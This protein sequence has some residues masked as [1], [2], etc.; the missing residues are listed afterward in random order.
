MNT[1]RLIARGLAHHWRTHLG[2][3]I[4][5]ACATAVLVGA[6][7]VGDSVRLS[8]REQA[9]QRVGRFES[10]L[11][12]GDRF[13]TAELA[14]RIGATLDA[15][16]CAALQLPGV[17]NRGEGP[18][19]AGI[20]DVYGVGDGFF[21][22]SS[23]GVG[24]PAP[25]PGH[26][27]LNRRIAD[28]LGV[29]VGDEL[30]LRVEKPSLMPQEATMATVD[31]V[32]H[33][34][35]VA[36][37][38]VLEDH[39]FG[40]F[41]LRASQVPPFNVFVSRAWLA[42]ELG[43]AGRANL[44]LADVEAARGDAAFAERW[45]LEDAELELIEHA[46]GCELRS[47]RVFL[48]DA[49]V[50]AAAGIAPDGLG[51]FTYFVNAV[52]VGD[53]ATPYS[54]ICG[55]GPLRGGARVAEGLAGL[56]ALAPNT[57]DGITANAWLAEDLRANAGA[58]AELRYYVMN[59][60]LQLKEQTQ[61]LRLTAVAPLAGA[62]ADPS[63]MPEFPGLA[64]ARSCTDWEPGVPVE[65]DQLDDRDQAYWDEHRGTPKG[66]VTLA[67]ARAMWANRFG[68]LTAV[69]A[70][71]DAAPLL[72]DG[73]L[74]RLPPA[75][76]GLFFQDLR[77][78]ALAS[79]AP[80][81]DFGALYLGLSF[82]LIVAALLL[83]VLLFVFGVERRAGEVGALLAVGYEPR[84]VRSLFVQEAMA[85]TLLGGA[86][87]AGAG[88]GYA[89]GVLSG[90]D[91][92]WQD[93]VG[94]ATIRAFVE[95]TTLLLGG[96]SVVAVSMAAIWWAVRRA[97]QR[98]AVE[99]LA[100]RG[101]LEASSV[102]PSRATR[103]ARASAAMAAAVGAGALWMI[104]SAEPARATSAFFGGGALLLIGALL[105][106]R[107][108]LAVLGAPK[109]RPLASVAGLAA[110]N[111]GRRPGR[112]LATIALLASGA[113]LVLAI[114]AN[115]LAPPRD[116]ALRSSGTGGF[117]LFGRSTLPVLRDLGT[118]EARDAYALDDDA[119]RGVDVVPLRVRPGDDASCLNLATAQNP[120]LVGV[121]A[122]RLASRSAFRF[123]RTID[124]PGPGDGWDLLDRDLGP[125]VVPAIGDGGS[126]AWAL[127]KKVG[128]A[129]R[130]R[131]E[132]GRDFD[133]RIVGTVADSI[134]QGNLL[135]AD[136]HMRARFPSAS[137][138]RMFLVDAPAAR[139]DAVRDDLSDALSDIGLELTPTEQRLASFQTIQNTYLSIFQ[140]LGGLG[141]L[142]GTAG[143]GVVVLRNTLERR[144][145]LA[146]THALGYS[147]GAVR[148]MV[149][150]E[151]ALLLGA[152]LAVGAL[153]AAVAMI[154][155]WTEGRAAS[156]GSSA[157][158]VVALATT[159]AF[160]VWAAGLLALRGGLLDRLRAD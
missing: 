118:P 35:R 137:G 22:M 54:M 153:A 112:S 23:G 63:L 11:A 75:E 6:L 81:T 123:T 100:A 141:L 52:R 10:V 102:D 24:R 84:R 156:F 109:A 56:A 67:R 87:G 107:A 114:Q 9:L 58:E 106:C 1:W 142:L 61:Q 13:V 50:E 124:G 152:G 51:L 8:L 48:D 92:L 157:L 90:L 119:L 138:F 98:P 39:E 93:T 135:I 43:L 85:L 79:G 21:S 19:R 34:L 18:A 158:L 77:G 121:L 74:R 47:D 89:S 133:V 151:H 128:D 126:V 46:S 32:A 105:A 5:V 37:D 96:A 69:R 49:V 78:P 36:V 27:L 148:R 17:A 4:G 31:D 95:P 120:Q 15:R 82:F 103:R 147:D 30:V 70:P 42:E 2:V 83:T 110:R 101:G 12:C 76:L 144:S 14:E 91:T 122:D 65:L 129:L 134:L 7:V 143:L 127:Q 40:R 20:V 149:W 94:Q 99:L 33:A 41:G 71:A 57:D 3:L 117:A 125:D 136:Q 16:A 38:E 104:L 155:T 72:R 132:H 111:A 139:R 160:W 150:I 73:L 55:V 86:L 60:Q 28:Q 25:P 108:W 130:Y 64:E 66:F 154:P 97:A 53:R 131:D 115:R 113:F 140:L 26:A 159:G 146:V 44:V 68:T 29:G 80:A 45:R 62:A 145:E 59:E 116:P 88:I